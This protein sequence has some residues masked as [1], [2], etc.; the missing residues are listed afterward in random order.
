MSLFKIAKPL[1]FRFS[2]R[3]STGIGHW[4][5][6]KQVDVQQFYNLLFLYGDY[7][8]PKKNKKLA[9]DQL[10]YYQNVSLS[11]ISLKNRNRENLNFLGQKTNPIA[12]EEQLWWALDFWEGNGSLSWRPDVKKLKSLQIRVVQNTDGLCAFTFFFRTF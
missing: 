5:V 12:L 11:L 1:G 8:C 10:N 9:F 3:T 4:R 7:L 6:K 2:F